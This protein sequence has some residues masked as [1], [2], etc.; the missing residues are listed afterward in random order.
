MVSEKKRP[1]DSSAFFAGLLHPLESVCSILFGDRRNDDVMLNDDEADVDVEKRPRLSDSSTDFLRSTTSLSSSDED[2]NSSEEDVGCSKIHPEPPLL[3]SLSPLLEEKDKAEDDRY[4]KLKKRSIQLGQGTFGTVVAL[5]ENGAALAVKMC[6]MFDVN[7]VVIQENVREAF[8][9]KYLELDGFVRFKRFYVSSTSGAIRLTMPRAMCDLH[10]WCMS[11][12]VERRVAMLPKIMAD[13]STALIELHDRGVMHGDLKPQNILVYYEKG[14][15]VFRPADLGASSMIGRHAAHDRCTYPFRPP[16]GFFAHEKGRRYDDRAFDAYSLGAVLFFVL[17][18][19][20]PAGDG[21]MHPARSIGVD[22]TTGREQLTYD[23]Q[24]SED[25]HASGVVR[26]T[27]ADVSKHDALPDH[28]FAAIKSLLAH[29]P[30]ERMTIEQAVLLADPTSEFGRDQAR[31]KWQIR[32]MLLSPTTL[33]DPAAEGCEGDRR[34]IA[35]ILDEW[36]PDGQHDIREDMIV[37]ARNI[38]TWTGASCSVA[39]ILAE[40]LI[41]PN[42]RYGGSIEAVGRRHEIRAALGELISE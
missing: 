31:R 38:R 28:L 10:R 35:G 36:L 2:E 6:D 12:S 23:R 1:R 25:A 18:A 21:Y 5:S 13:V 15:V 27:L 4:E 7:G 19:N 42:V 26:R 17:T 40:C 8:F 39:V 3:D 34:E 16:E 24:C 9:S 37:C 32:D 22:P 41:L 14:L 20:T 33:C 30:D 11:T 29:D